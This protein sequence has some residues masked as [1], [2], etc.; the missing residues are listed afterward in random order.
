MRP[1]PDLGP[2][3][4]AL[5]RRYDRRWLESDP[6]RWPRRFHDPRDRE[7]VAV[8]AALLAYGRVASIQAS[9][10]AVLAALPARPSD[11]LLPR[12]RA[13]LPDRLRAFRHR[14]TA[15]ADLAWCLESV[16]RAWDD[17]GSLGAFVGRTALGPDRLRAALVAW[18]RL[19]DEVPASPAPARRRAREFL[20]PDAGRGAAC[21]RLA[22]LAR[23]CVRPDDGLDLGL[24]TE[25]LSPRDLVLPLDTHVHR[26]VA[27][28][29][30]VR[31]KTPSWAAAREAAAA[32]SRYDRDDPVRFDFALARPGILGACLHR[33]VADVCGPCDLRTVCAHGRR[34]RVAALTT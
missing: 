28:L 10:A 3:L 21:K 31:R 24:W 9:I 26:L 19:A 18:R 15:G 5:A 32:L 27:H 8:V 12:H 16:G 23:W 33:P 20:L 1:A 34:V 7:V 11:A 14:F 17:A 6:L 4:D 30:L 22:L 13:D 29:G 25:G 2:R